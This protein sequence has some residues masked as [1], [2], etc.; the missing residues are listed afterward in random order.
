MKE[1][2]YTKEEVEIWKIKAGQ[3]DRLDEKIGK[4]YTND[5]DELVEDGEEPQNTGDL[6]DIGELAATEFG[7]MH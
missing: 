1:I 4:F 5:K 2:N 3:W 7:W 6:T